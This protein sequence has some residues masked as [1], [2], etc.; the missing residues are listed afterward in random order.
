MATTDKSDLIKKLTMAQKFV[1]L[2]KKLLIL[3]KV[4]CILLLNNLI[5]VKNITLSLSQAN[6][7][8]KADFDDF[9]EKKD[10][11]DKLKN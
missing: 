4:I 5:N 6:I 10:F 3:I 1:K 8:T 2:K 7:G 11:D 9:M